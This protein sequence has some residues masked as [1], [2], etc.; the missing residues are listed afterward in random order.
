MA[1]T[2]E[3]HGNLELYCRRQ[4]RNSKGVLERFTQVGVEVQG[5]HEDFKEELGLWEAK[6]MNDLLTRAQPYI[7]YKEKKLTEEAFTSKHS[8]KTSSNT[9]RSDNEKTKGSRPHPKD[10]TPLN[11]SRETILRKCYATQFKEASMKSPQSLK[12]L[13]RTD[14]AKYYP[15]HRSRDHDTEECF[16]LQEA[17][18]DLIKKGKLSDVERTHQES[19][20]KRNDLQKG[21]NPLHGRCGMPST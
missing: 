8:N 16:Q 4:E 15:Y 13:A 10:Y 21:A 3:N 18:E 11:A 19:P 1:E 5:T 9:R 6:D 12:E 14:K 2:A 17:I 20:R 7:T